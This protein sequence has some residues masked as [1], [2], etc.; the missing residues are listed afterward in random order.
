VGNVTHSVQNAG[1]A[2][3]AFQNGLAKV[4]KVSK[5]ELEKRVAEDNRERT[6]DRVQRGYAK[7]G[8]KTKR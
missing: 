8:P 1:E 4:L 6:A 2:Y 3:V 5:A 7:R